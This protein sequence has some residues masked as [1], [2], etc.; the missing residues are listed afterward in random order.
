MHRKSRGYLRTQR[1][2]GVESLKASVT[3]ARSRYTCKAFCQASLLQWL[4]R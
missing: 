2:G 4:K 1:H 3:A